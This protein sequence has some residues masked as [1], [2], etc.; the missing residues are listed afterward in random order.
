MFGGQY[1][2]V[3][4]RIGLDLLLY[5]VLERTKLSNLYLFLFNEEGAASIFFRDAAGLHS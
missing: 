3:L 5:L 1:Y 4:D 2:I